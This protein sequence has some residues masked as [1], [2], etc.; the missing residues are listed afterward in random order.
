MLFIVLKLIL[1]LLLLL[2]NNVIKCKT[3]QCVNTRQL[4]SERKSLQFMSGHV[5]RDQRTQFSRKT[6][7]HTTSIDGETVITAVCRS[8]RH[9]HK[10]VMIIAR[11][12]ICYGYLLRQELLRKRHNSVY[13]TWKVSCGNQEPPGS[14][15]SRYAHCTEINYTFFQK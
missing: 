12:L 1:L 5:K 15:A 11:K 9:S 7:P 4:L 2:L 3:V 10:T 13:D 8:A 14:I 6:V